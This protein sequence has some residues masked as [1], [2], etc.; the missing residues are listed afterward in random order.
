MITTATD[1]QKKFAAD[2]FAMENG[3]I[4]TD[5]EEAKKISAGILEKKN[6]GIFSEFPLLGEVPEE[7]TICGSEEQLEECCGKIVICEKNPQ[8]RKTGVLY[9]LPRNLYVGMG[10]K[11]GTAKEILEAELL[12]ILEKHGFLP[13]QIRALG[14]I[15]LKREEDGLLEL[16]DSLGVE[17]LTY[18]AESLQEISAVSS[19]SEFVRGVTGVDNVCERAAKKMCPEGVMVQEKV[20][21]NQCT[22]AVVCGEVMVRFGKEEEER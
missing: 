1:V 16:A 20:C 12:K 11:K 8:N 9:L 14:S 15:D 5:R 22:A 10:C 19:S 6:T 4:I 13:E 17:F 3:L 18:S 2:V 21:L 7:L